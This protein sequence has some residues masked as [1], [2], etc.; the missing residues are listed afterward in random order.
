MYFSPYFSAY[1]TFHLSLDFFE[2]VGVGDVEFG[3]GGAAKG[4]EMG[5]GA[6]ALT[7]FVGDRTH[8]GSRGYAGAEMGAVALDCENGEFFD[9]DLDRLQDYLFLFSCQFVGGDAVD[10]LGGEWRRNLLDHAVKSGSEFLDGLKAESDREGVTGGFAV[11]VIGVGGE[12][13][14][15]DAFVGFLGRR[16]ELGQAGEAAGDQGEHA[17]G[18]R[19]EGAE[20]A[21][22]ALARVCGACG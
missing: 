7:H 14:A 15:D 11:G 1:L 12:A 10:L 22:G 2:G 8:V 16:V 9:L 3:Y 18:E 20:M 19:V 6:Q 5:A 21:D 4:F 13:E 17:G